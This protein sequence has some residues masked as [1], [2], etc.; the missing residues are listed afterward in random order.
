MFPRRRGQPPAS[1]GPPSARAEVAGISDAKRLV[2]RPRL[3]TIPAYRPLDIASSYGDAIVALMS[4]EPIH[5]FIISGH[6]R[7]EMERRGISDEVVRQVLESPEQRLQ[8]LK[9]R[10]VLHTHRCSWELRRGRRSR[11]AR[12]PRRLAAGS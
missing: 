10:V 7:F 8:T 9:G 3:R 4:P 11:V 2:A 6:A 12:D 5:E 1:R